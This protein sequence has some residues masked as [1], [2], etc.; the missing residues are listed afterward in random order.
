MRVQAIL[1]V[2]GMLVVVPTMSRG[3]TVTYID[4]VAGNYRIETISNIEVF[5]TYH[6]AMFTPGLAF[7]P[8]DWH[9]R[10]CCPSPWPCHLITNHLECF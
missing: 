3:D 8:L 4:A 5:G 10:I 9:S 6:D 2:L 7:L 1:L